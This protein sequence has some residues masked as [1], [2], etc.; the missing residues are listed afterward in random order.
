MLDF[1][2]HV[3]KSALHN[4]KKKE[5]IPD[6]VMTIL[7]GVLAQLKSINSQPEMIKD[8]ITFDKVVCERIY[9]QFSG[10]NDVGP[11]YIPYLFDLTNL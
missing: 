10:T 2:S 11:F 3:Y 6:S 7:M 5:N 8:T 4:Y 9:L 1:A